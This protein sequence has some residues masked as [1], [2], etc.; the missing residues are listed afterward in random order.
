[1]ESSRILQLDLLLNS[2]KPEITEE[3]SVD[4]KRV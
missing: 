4:G 2:T 1:M 3:N